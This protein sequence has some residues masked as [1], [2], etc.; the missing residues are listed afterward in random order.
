MFKTLFHK[1]T[2]QSECPA[3]CTDQA[4]DTDDGN[5]QTLDLKL[6]PRYDTIGRVATQLETHFCATVTA[7]DIPDDDESIRAPVDIVVAL[8]ISASM[9]GRKLELCKET[10][11]LLLRELSLRDRFGLVTFG[12]EAEIQIPARKLTKA[13]KEIAIRKINNLRTKGCTNLSDGIMLTMQEIKSI[14]S[15]NEVQTMFLLTDGLANRGISDRKGILQHTQICIPSG[16]LAIHCFGYGV[17]HDREMLRDISQATDGGTYYFV[18]N[19]SD[20][21]SA[22]GDAIG[23]VLS[24]V[25]QNTVL[26]FDA[27]NDHSVRITDILHDKA[28]KQESGS[29]TVDLGDFY[30]EESRDIILNVALAS[31]SDL[32]LE[33]IPHLSASMTYMDTINKKLAKCESI[34]GSILRPDG[35]EVSQ[36]NEHVALQY[37]RVSITKTIA[38]AEQIATSGNLEAAK[39]KINSA[40]EYLNRESATF[41]ESYPLISQLL[42][43]LN[44][45][46]SGL[47]TRDM[48]ESRG[49]CYMQERISTH[50]NQRCSESSTVATMNV[51][52]SSKKSK[53]SSNLSSGF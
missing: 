27:S 15:P 45:I 47:S 35:S 48:W 19:D 14:E 22:F 16:T 6:T 25:A 8:D 30:A 32:G 12:S 33:P 2:D 36:V 20:V 41:D 49:S 53:C 24:V 37:I 11:T 13:N 43:E 17:D 39:S 26:T 40:I 52:R 51:Y 38:E 28:V 4:M 21:A 46:L 23:G 18:E 44:T 42:G 7:R 50:Q 1:G 5:L 29:Y 34:Q 9:D 31:G 10:L 3:K